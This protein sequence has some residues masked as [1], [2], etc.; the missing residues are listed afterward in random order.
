[1]TKRFVN[2]ALFVDCILLLASGLALLETSRPQDAWLYTFHRIAGAALILLLIPKSRIIWQALARQFRRGAWLN[3]TTLAA[4]VL[5]AGLAIVLA[6]ALAW[7]LNWLPFYVQLV[8][9]VTPLGLHWYLVFP[10]IPFFAWHAYKRWPHSRA[11]PASPAP[12]SIP[13]ISR[14]TALSLLGVSALALLG[15]AALEDLAGTAGW[16]RRFTGSRLVA[17]GPGNDFPVTNSDALPDIDLSSWRLVVSGRVARPLALSYSDLLGL[18]DGSTHATIDCTLGWAAGREWRGVR[19]S[20][21]LARAGA[22]HGA[23]QVT[24]RAV[25]GYYSVLDLVEAQDALIA[26]EVEGERLAAAHG[27]PARLVAPTRRGFQW[28]K[29]LSEIRVE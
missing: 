27:F 19:L 12:P 13:A 7:T 4:I 15:F 14:R 8:L 26:T 11:A 1:M 2:L 25:T 29:W 24:C 17:A 16:P 28:T 9:S 18:A 10:L 5:T 3:W 23:R 20:E 22:E 6:F 21:L